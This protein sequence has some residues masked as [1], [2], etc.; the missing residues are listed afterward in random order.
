MFL[1][2]LTAMQ[3]LAASISQNHLNGVAFC[4]TLDLVLIVILFYSII[5]KCSYFTEMRLIEM[6]LLSEMY[7]LQLVVLL[8]VLQTTT[9]QQNNEE[10]PVCVHTGWLEHTLV[11]SA[12]C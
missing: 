6:C 4:A 10:A 3:A 1:D 9:F 12:L 11:T 7:R 8:C 5:I 2:T